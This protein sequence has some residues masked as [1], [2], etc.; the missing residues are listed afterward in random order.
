MATC[1]ANRVASLAL[2]FEL[3]E[4]GANLS[5]GER[6]LLCL[7]RAIARKSRLVLMDE[8]TANV[9]QKTDR[10][11]QRVLNGGAPAAR[12]GSP[13]RTASGRSRP[14]TPWRSS[15]TASS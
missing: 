11:V 3:S 15:T 6:Q 12:R 13:S 8:A 7:A 4:F 2:D 5:V 9:D 14:A 1:V 10:L